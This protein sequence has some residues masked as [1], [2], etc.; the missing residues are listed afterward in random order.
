MNRIN[1]SGYYNTID[2][3]DEKYQ[4]NRR[5]NI[6]HFGNMNDQLKSKYKFI[7]PSVLQNKTNEQYSYDQ[8]E[9]RRMYEKRIETNNLTQSQLLI[10]ISDIKAIID[11]L[12]S[13]TLAIE[14]YFT[15][16]SFEKK[17][18][19]N[20]TKNMLFYFLLTTLISE[21]LD[22][23]SLELTEESSESLKSELE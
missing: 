7:N 12:K 14:H 10:F 3:D 2:S 22:S 18:S 13:S 21:S 1:P 15:N 16:T 4:N 23:E 20:D 8:Q 5:N 9:F 19:I 6:E 11:P 17:N